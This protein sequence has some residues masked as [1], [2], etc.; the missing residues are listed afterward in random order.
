MFERDANGWTP[1][2][3]ATLVREAYSARYQPED[4][5]A[6]AT[7]ESG[8]VTTR[9]PPRGPYAH[10]L[11]GHASGLW[12]AMPEILHNLGFPGTHADFREVGIQTQLEWFSKYVEDWRG[13][14]HFGEFRTGGALYL[15]N[16]APAHLGHKDDPDFIIFDSRKAKEAATWRVNRGLDRP[17]AGHP[18][19]PDPVDPRIKRKGYINVRDLIVTVE[20]CRGLQVYKTA[21]TSLNKMAQAGL[22]RAGANLVEDGAIGP[23]SLAAFKAWAQG[24]P[25]Q[26]LDGA[27]RLALLGS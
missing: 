13:R 14:F 15:L 27:A 17:Q 1:E 4:F 23:L 2:D 3:Y 19:I 6:F 5:L 9:T 20:L 7:N 24:K 26:R 8:L 18:E 21:V 10:N 16:F 11:S 12:Q 22:N 25:Y